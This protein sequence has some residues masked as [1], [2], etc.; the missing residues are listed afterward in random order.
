MDASNSLMEIIQTLPWTNILAGLGVLFGIITLL[1]YIDQKR[2]NRE[3]KTVITYLQREL[4]RDI[5]EEEINKLKNK[6]DELES[7]VK[8][9]IPK[10]G[11]IAILQDQSE[12]YQSVISDN[13][14]SFEGIQ[15]KLNQLGANDPA[16]E[17][18]PS[19]KNF[20]LNEISPKYRLK[21]IKN[22]VVEKIFVLFAL[23][24]VAGTIM[25]TNYLI[26]V[27]LSLVLLFEVL[28]YYILNSSS[29]EEKEE[30]YKFS[31][32]I[33]L[34]P[35]AFVLAVIILMLLD[36]S[37]NI[38]PT[39]KIL[40]YLLIVV[41]VLILIFSKRIINSFRARIEKTIRLQ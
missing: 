34:I 25:P 33:L 4:D 39:N 19:M 20:I 40:L 22:K 31:K 1:G 24:F 16:N 13:F 7:E 21:N 23:I 35:S 38:N 26:K 18:S 29:E 27:I 8:E 30:K 28:K 5:T 3:L 14:K 10:A 2:S 17:L 41:L 32:L 11:K 36:P 9:K 37:Q 12:Y 15:T 6:K